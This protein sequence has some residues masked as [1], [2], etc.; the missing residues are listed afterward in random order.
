MDSGYGRAGITM[1]DLENLKYLNLENK[2]IFL[3]KNVNGKYGR[4]L[5][6]IRVGYDRLYMYYNLSK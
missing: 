1:T 2:I 5:F 3:L 6:Y 4:N